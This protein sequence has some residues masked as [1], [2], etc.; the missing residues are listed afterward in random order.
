MVGLMAAMVDNLVTLCVGPLLLC[1]Q[2]A[3]APDPT[4]RADPFGPDKT[5]PF[6]AI[7][8]MPHTAAYRFLP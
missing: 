8:H 7:W 5:Q 1:L 6:F 3:S 4:Q 2:L